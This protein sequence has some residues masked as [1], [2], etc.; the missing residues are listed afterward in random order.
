MEV[1][2]QI[3]FAGFFAGAFGRIF[4]L[5]ATVTLCMDFWWTIREPQLGILD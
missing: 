1:D 2:V 5:F 4:A 3:I